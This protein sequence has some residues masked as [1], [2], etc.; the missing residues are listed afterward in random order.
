MPDWSAGNC[1]FRVIEQQAHYR[2]ITRLLLS[3]GIRLEAKSRI[4]VSICSWP[5]SCFSAYG[6]RV[7]GITA[8]KPLE[9]SLSR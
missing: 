9:D 3:N 4:G 2:P 5:Q 8:T 6:A 1:P 7:A